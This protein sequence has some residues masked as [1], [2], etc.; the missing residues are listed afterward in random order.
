MFGPHGGKL[1]AST[2]AYP[3]RLTCPAGIGRDGDKLGDNE[4]GACE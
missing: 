1:S 2:Y 3:E 4:I